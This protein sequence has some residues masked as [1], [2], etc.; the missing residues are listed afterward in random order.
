MFTDYV[1]IC[2]FGMFTATGAAHIT[3]TPTIKPVE[4]SDVDQSAYSSASSAV[5]SASRKKHIIVSN[6]TAPIIIILFQMS[7]SLS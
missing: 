3:P 7:S 1:A 2:S 5:M 6:N 4:L